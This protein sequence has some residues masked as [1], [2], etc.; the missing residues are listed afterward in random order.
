MSTLTI[1]LLVILIV[2]VIACVV[3]YFLGKRAEKKQAAQ[4]EQLDA[5]AQTVSMLIIDKGK[6]RLKD[7]GFPPVVVEGTP[8]YLRRSKVPVVKAKVG[9]KVMT[10]MCDAQV[11]PVIPVKKEVKATVS[12]IYITGVKGLRGPLETPPKKKGFFKRI[13]GR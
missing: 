7:A 5:A 3:L 4:Q 1:V 13:T 8:K 12:G 6:M 2:L 10:L 9:P 11:F